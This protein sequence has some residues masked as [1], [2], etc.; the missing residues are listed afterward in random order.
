[1]LHKSDSADKLYVSYSRVYTCLLYIVIAMYTGF[2]VPQKI[3]HSY[4]NI[5]HSGFS[6][7]IYCYNAKS[8]WSMDSGEN[9][10]E[11]RDFPIKDGKTCNFSRQPIPI[12]LRKP[13]LRSQ[14]P[15]SHRQRCYGPPLSLASS[16]WLAVSPS[17]SKSQ[18]VSSG[19]L[20]T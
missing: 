14:K 4:L 19:D 20:H 12:H 5:F 8:P 18:E 16:L 1:M 15:R 3:E 10:Q 9:L 2:S 7:C 13:N 11:T 6:I 17:A